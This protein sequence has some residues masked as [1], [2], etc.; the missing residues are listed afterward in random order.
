MAWEYSE[1]TKQLFLDAVSGKPGTHLGE[2][3][4]P[5]G[6]GEHGS[7]ACGDSLRFT[8]RCEKNE[9]PLKDKIVETRYLTFGCTSAIAASE[10]LCMLLE[11]KSCTPIEA[12][13]IT[14]Q[15]IVD[16][17]Q[18]LPNQK[19]HCS[20][21]GAEAL[22]AAV[23]FW[24]KKRGVDLEA[25]GVN[26][27]EHEAEEEGRLVCKCFSITEPY[28]R[29]KIRELNLRTVE[30]VTAALKAGGACGSC[31]HAPGG[32]E[33][34]LN[35]VWATDSALKASANAGSLPEAM[36]AAGAA[37][38][39]MGTGSACGVATAGTGATGMTGAELPMAQAGGAAMPISIGTPSAP[40]GAG[41]TVPS[42][43]A[44]GAALSPYQFAKKVEAV[45]DRSVRPMLQMD[46]G[47]IEIVDIKGTLVYVI[48]HGACS[49]C[50]GA[51]A[52][53]KMVVE[54][55]LQDGVDPGIKVI[56]V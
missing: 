46:G 39:A 36:A 42:A 5:D 13:K 34:I 48:L 2:I 43:A 32:I 38:E 45:I 8:F 3:K 44:T 20:V 15:D 27:K 16:F 22:E 28:L 24:A 40:A 18:G 29:R 33:D 1:K 9:D 35:D 7:I 23:F 49:N 30:D 31:I 11:E 26:M 41:V 51:D 47:D 54:R 17:L 4:D 10:A 55:L 19:I 50:A 6:F 12:L 37:V 56:Q 53:L 14:N 25:L 21:M 52:T